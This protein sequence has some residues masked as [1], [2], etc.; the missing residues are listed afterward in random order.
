MHFITFFFY[1]WSHDPYSLGPGD[2]STKPFLSFESKFSL[3]H[4]V[5]AAVS[6]NLVMVDNANQ[7]NKILICHAE[8]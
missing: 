2:D 1:T 4:S 6:R 5:L 7:M 3:H 8:A